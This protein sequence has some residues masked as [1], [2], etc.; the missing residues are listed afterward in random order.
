MVLLLLLFMQKTKYIF[1]RWPFGNDPLFY[2]DLLWSFNMLASAVITSAAK[3]QSTR[4]LLCFS[5]SPSKDTNSRADGIGGGDSLKAWALLLLGNHFTS[6]CPLHLQWRTTHEGASMLTF[7]T[8]AHIQVSSRNV[9][10][11]F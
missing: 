4:E 7:S 6:F 9:C 3:S 11:Q 10:T 1:N 8:L 2:R 5:R